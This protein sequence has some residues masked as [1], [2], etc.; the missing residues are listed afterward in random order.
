MKKCGHGKMS[1]MSKGAS[2]YGKPA[3]AKSAKSGGKTGMKRTTA[4][5][6]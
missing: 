5:R 4:R 6:K 2:S 3:S 1:G